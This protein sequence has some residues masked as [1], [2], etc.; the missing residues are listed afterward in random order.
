MIVS[1]QAL[2]IALPGITRTSGILRRRLDTA[3]G[4][5]ATRLI[6]RCFRRAK[7]MMVAVIS[8]VAGVRMEPEGGNIAVRVTVNAQGRAPA[9]LH[10][11]DE[12]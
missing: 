10:R 4:N 3:I 2:A 5:T 1:V 6:T 11:H 9:E 8:S 12:H 7:T